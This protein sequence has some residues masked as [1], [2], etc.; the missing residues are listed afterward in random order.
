MR[1]IN[2]RRLEQSL[3]DNQDEYLGTHPELTGTATYLHGLLEHMDDVIEQQRY[4]S[5]REDDYSLKHI[6]AELDGLK[7]ALPPVKKAIDLIMSNAAR[8]EA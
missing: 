2:R 5:Q 3:H 6:E 4:S 8:R 1:P 7:E